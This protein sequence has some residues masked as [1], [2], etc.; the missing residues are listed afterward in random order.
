MMEPSILDKEINEELQKLLAL[1]GED[2]LVQRYQQLEKKVQ[3]SQKLTDLVEQIKVAQKDAVQFA[4][5]DK[6]EA[7]K[8]AIQRAN[9]LTEEFDDHPL[10]IAYREQLKE[11]NDL[12]QHVTNIIQYRVNEELEKEG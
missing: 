10:V 6:P 9:A 4:H 2:E 8:A 12:L 11:V 7:E 5:Y 1:I 3:K